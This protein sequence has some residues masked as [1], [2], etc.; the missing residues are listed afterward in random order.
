MEFVSFVDARKRMPNI[1]GD[2]IE[3]LTRYENGSQYF[4]TAEEDPEQKDEMRVHLVGPIATEPNDTREFTPDKVRSI[5]SIK[6]M[7]LS[8]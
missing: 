3:F 2:S 4:L 6:N 1:K 8:I 5:K 7:V